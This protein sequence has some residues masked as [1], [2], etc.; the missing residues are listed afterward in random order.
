MSSATVFTEVVHRSSSSIVTALTEVLSAWS[1]R[2]ELTSGI[3]Q[4]S[5]YRV[6]YPSILC[7]RVRSTSSRD[8][9][10]SQ[11][12]DLPLRVLLRGKLHGV[13]RSGK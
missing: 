2:M 4:K 7:N 9:L 5:G 11:P 8:K 3:K 1:K 12:A 6:S 10:V 13:D